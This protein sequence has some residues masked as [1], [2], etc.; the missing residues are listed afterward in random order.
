MINEPAPPPPPPQAS[1]QTLAPSSS[2]RSLSNVGRKASINSLTND[3]DIDIRGNETPSITRISATSNSSS[4]SNSPVIH[5]PALPHTMSTATFPPPPQFQSQQKQQQQQPPLVLPSSSS[6][7][8]H[9]HHHQQSTY[10]NQQHS[11]PISPHYEQ[12]MISPI[13]GRPSSSSI[14][15]DSNEPTAAPPPTTTTFNTR[16]TS[17]IASLL[18]NDT[19]RPAPKD[20][21]SVD[22]FP[23]PVAPPQAH[24]QQGFAQPFQQQPQ[25][26]L[27]PVKQEQ[28]SDQ[29]PRTKSISDE[30]EQL[31]QLEKTTVKKP[32]KYDT[33][34][35][36]A[37]NWIPLVSD[38]Q[39]RTN[40]GYPGNT[41]G[42]SG[43]GVNEVEK[44]RTKLSYNENLDVSITKVIPYEDLTRKVTQWLYSHLYDLRQNEP[45]LLGFLELE[46]KLGRIWS[47]ELDS[48]IELPIS[49]EVI[50]TDQINYY[51]K[52]GVEN[53]MFVKIEDFLMKQNAK[54]AGKKFTTL[55]S[56]T[57]DFF[58]QGIIRGD[59]P[60]NL[61]V[62][63][64]KD[65]KRIINQIEKRRVGDLFIHNPSNILDFRLS[66]SLEI[67]I[68]D[69]PKAISK[70]EPN[71]RRHKVR[72][73]YISDA[74]KN[75]FDLT[76]TYTF[77]QQQQGK[78]EQNY[79]IE[80]EIEPNWLLDSFNN[81]FVST[82]NQTY[83]D[84]VKVMLDN[85]R[86][87]NRSL[88]S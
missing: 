25:P 83:E 39:N 4:V 36:W 76:K 38:K 40:G 27:H 61:R 2:V 41:G 1:T 30:L 32:K 12:P 48:R 56:D 9:H 28:N 72:T 21:P 42:G 5:R 69:I 20:G 51:F 70:T 81:L 59:K 52:P 62:S 3:N 77:H 68:K 84:T 86:I 65:T 8:H 80:I 31:E 49:T 58:Y 63:Q 75:K 35:I 55:K 78:P 60:Y 34:P 82:D 47:K 46:L 43:G 73:S 88:S 33:P 18:S 22:H 79:E 37:Q 10:F 19:L 14:L 57:M 6:S 16:K 24:Q 50:V 54:T 67:P 26:Q 87:L 71:M 29:Q 17:S 74:C 66:L 13:S 53:P 44:E 15:N 11:N 45:E 7:Q 85:S 64:D 23:T